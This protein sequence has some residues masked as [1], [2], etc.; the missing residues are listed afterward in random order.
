MTINIEPIFH[1]LLLILKPSPLF[2]APEKKGIYY[3]H[4]KYSDP[5]QKS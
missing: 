5:Y 1:A 2:F 4:G 3:I